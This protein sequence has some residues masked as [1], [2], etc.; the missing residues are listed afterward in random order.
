MDEIIEHTIEVRVAEGNRPVALPGNWMP[1]GGTDI[2]T[3]EDLIK[4]VEILK[5]SSRLGGIGEPP[6]G[7]V[8]FYDAIRITLVLTGQPEVKEEP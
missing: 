5:E 7:A 4:Y 2:E 8:Q 6:L 3:V 1:L